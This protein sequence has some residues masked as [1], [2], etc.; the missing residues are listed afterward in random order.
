MRWS[1]ATGL[2]LRTECQRAGE[3]TQMD[4]S[5]IMAPRGNV[6]PRDSGNQ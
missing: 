6:T 5:L 4:C 1:F 3:T 2:R